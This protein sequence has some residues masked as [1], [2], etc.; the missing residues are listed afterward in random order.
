MLT[1]DVRVS[2]VIAAPYISFAVSSLHPAS[3]HLFLVSLREPSSSPSPA[4]V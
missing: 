3:L 2:V 4:M 1:G